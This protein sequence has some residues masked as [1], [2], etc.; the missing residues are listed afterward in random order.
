MGFPKG[1]SISLCS[2]LVSGG[3]NTPAAKWL[4]LRRARLFVV[5]KTNEH[6]TLAAP[7]PEEAKLSTQPLALTAFGGEKASAGAGHVVK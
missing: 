7:K 1:A 3:V 2:I 4:R 5:N 6:G